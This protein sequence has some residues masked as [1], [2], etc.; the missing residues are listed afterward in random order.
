MRLRWRSVPAAV[1]PALIGTVLAGAGSVLASCL[2]LDLSS[3]PRTDQTAVFAGTVTA[4]QSG[5]VFMNVEAWFFGQDPVG[6]AEVIGGNASNEP[7]VVTSADWSP[8]P[9]ERWLVVAEQATAQGFR[10][11]PCQQ[12]AVDDG[13]LERATTIFGAAQGPPFATPGSGSPSSAQSA[14]P[15]GSASSSPVPSATPDQV[16][17]PT[18]GSNFLPALIIALIILGVALSAWRLTRTSPTD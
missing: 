3:I 5:H 7:G 13:V 16:W 12:V 14:A 10:T 1:A 6:S 18:R 15:G 17:N 9:G 11:Q 8:Q 4:V 2:P